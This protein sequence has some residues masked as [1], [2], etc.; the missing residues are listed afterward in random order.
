M[1]VVPPGLI[2]TSKPVE[3]LIVPAAVLEDTHT[4]PAS[5][6]EIECG[7]GDAAQTVTCVLAIVPA[8]GNA[9]IVTL[10]VVLA[11][12]VPLDTCTVKAS[13]PL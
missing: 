12:F 9:A 8:V 5:P 6:P 11:V 7:S 10:I 3:A 1:V 2:P 13:V 4:P